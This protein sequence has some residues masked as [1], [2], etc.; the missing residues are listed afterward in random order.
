MYWVSLITSLISL[1]IQNYDQVTF[2]TC[3]S[4]EILG[5]CQEFHK[6]YECRNW[7]DHSSE[8]V[9]KWSDSSALEST[10]DQTRA[11][12]RSKLPCNFGR[13]M[14]RRALEMVWTKTISSAHLDLGR[15][16]C[17]KSGREIRP[18]EI[19]QLILLFSMLKKWW[20]KWMKMRWRNSSS[21]HAPQSM[22]NN[23]TAASGGTSGNNG[24]GT[25]ASGGVAP[26]GNPG[27]NL[28]C[29]R[30]EEDY[31]LPEN[32]GLFEEYLEMG[33]L[34]WNFK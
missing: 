11:L 29:S 33:K 28:K 13:T 3:K 23:S 16:K 27:P 7:L 14:E 25:S 19:Q 26:P 21:H 10:S 8:S 1:L 4:C 32:E 30:L 9:M 15:L 18:D 5:N 6:T 31:M 34:N 2:Y 22:L 24:T 20:N 12:V 17:I